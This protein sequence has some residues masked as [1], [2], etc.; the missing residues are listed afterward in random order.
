MSSDLKASV[1]DIQLPP[2]KTAV[3]IGATTGIGAAVARKLASAGC[4]RVIILGRNRGRAE[5]VIG[6]MKELSEGRIDASFVNGDISHVRGIKDA[7]GSVRSALGE[8]Q[9]DYLV[10]CQNGPPTGTI[11]LNEDGEGT[12]FTVQVTSRFF[13]ACLFAVHQIMMSQTGKV[14]FIAN[15]GLSYDPL[16]VD[17][18]S[19]KRVAEKGRYRPLLTM[20]QSMR[21]STVLDSVILELNDRFPQYS[22]YHVHPGLVNTELF[23]IHTFPFPLSYIAGLGLM[24]MG[25]TPDEFANVPM[26]ILTN[27]EQFGDGDGK[28]W[29]HKL[30]PKPPGGWA[31]NQANRKKLWDKLLEMVGES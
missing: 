30:Q 13:L 11:N 8:D 29:N 16:D 5:V 9:V 28:F 15:P 21:D 1:N 27:S 31:S 26:K 10:M 22:F 3:V 23:D 2:N 17:D 4:K 19:L 18:L 7:F 12:E 6:R 25:T 14:M 20:D 24:I